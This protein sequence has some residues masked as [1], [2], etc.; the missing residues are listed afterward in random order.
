[1]FG[2]GLWFFGMHALWWVFWVVVIV[3][4]VAFVLPGWNRGERETPLEI[5]KRRYAAGEISKDEYE[6]RRATLTRDTDPGN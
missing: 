3:A 4:L 2:D 5:L 1:M 6:E